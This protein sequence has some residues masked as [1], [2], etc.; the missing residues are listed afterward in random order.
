MNQSQS[1]ELSRVRQEIDEID[2]QIVRLIAARGRQVTRAGE[3]KSTTSD[4]SVPTRVEAI[5]ER[6]RELALAEQVD[7]DLVEQIYRTMI[8]EFIQR[9]MQEVA[10]RTRDSDAGQSE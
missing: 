7:P 5:I 10:E 9:E 2:S 6:V 4:V 3:L 8:G 1:D